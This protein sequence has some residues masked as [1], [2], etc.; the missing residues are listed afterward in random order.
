VITV[1][2]LSRKSGAEQALLAI[3]RECNTP[4]LLRYQLASGVVLNAW[5]QHE[6]RFGSRALKQFYAFKKRM[7][8]LAQWADAQRYPD[9]H[10]WADRDHR[11]SGP[12]ITYIR[13]E[14]VDFSFHALPIG[15][16]L[17]GNGRSPAE[18]SGVRLK[19]IAP[20]VLE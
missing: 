13:I 18:W 19:P 6:Q 3:R 15:E 4:Q 17:I 14:N 10:V 20:L 16:K 9:V 5:I 11:S 2:S 1:N 7:N 12:A 8:E